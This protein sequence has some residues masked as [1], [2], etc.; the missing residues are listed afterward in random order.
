VE[1][2]RVR[3]DAHP[4]TGAHGVP[5]DVGRPSGAGA[6]RRPGPGALCRSG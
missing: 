1:R 3:L 6:P 5:R 4:R 2:P